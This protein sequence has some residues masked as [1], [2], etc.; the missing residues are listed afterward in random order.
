[1]NEL[2]LNANP[3]KVR[4]YLAAGL[5]VVS[6]DIPE[7]RKVGLCR[8][9][10]LAGGLPSKVD[11]CLAEGG[12]PT[13]RTRAE[14]IFHESWDARVDDIRQHVGEAAASG[15]AGGFDPARRPRSGAVPCACAP[16]A[17]RGL[18]AS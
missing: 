8:M 18:T 1:M 4:E 2:T 12:G 6:T 10:V 11:E 16:A 13:P 9:A 7:V 15:W 14:R 17:N 3:L 5:P